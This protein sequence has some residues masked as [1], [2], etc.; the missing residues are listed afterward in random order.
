MAEGSKPSFPNAQIYMTEADYAFWT[1]E[2]NLAIEPIKAMV[3]GT[4]NT[5]PPL[6]ERI[7]FVK[8][9]EELVP[10]V[11]LMATPGH[12][13]GHASYLLT[14]E[15]QTLAVIG[16]VVHHHILSTERP[17]LEFA[18]DS[19]PK[20]GVTTRVRILEMLA[21]QRLPFLAYHFPWPGMGNVTK[22]GDGFRYLPMPLKMVL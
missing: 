2:A 3:E 21:S 10:G 13:V 9:G 22:H 18:F 20:Q 7:K 17:Q 16:D 8:N 4:R 11:Q 15:G 14:S 5:L 12:T 19:D 1:D 6:R